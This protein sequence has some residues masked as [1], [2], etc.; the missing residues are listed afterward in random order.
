MV[1]GC[2]ASAV[3]LQRPWLTRQSDP[4]LSLSVVENSSRLL[5]DWTWRIRQPFF[6]ALPYSI[7]IVTF[8]SVDSE[9]ILWAAVGVPSVTFNTRAV[10]S[11][12]Y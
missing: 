2:L 3:A 9:A 8:V 1:P 5:G 10:V 6:L 11:S 12:I 4:A 7:R